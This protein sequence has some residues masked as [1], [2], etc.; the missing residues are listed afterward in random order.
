MCMHCE[1][2]NFDLQAYLF[3]VEQQQSLLGMIAAEYSL[4]FDM[5]S[6]TETY[7]NCLN[8]LTSVA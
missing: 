7:I 3:E 8:P 4:Y 2:W 5:L 6:E 1:F